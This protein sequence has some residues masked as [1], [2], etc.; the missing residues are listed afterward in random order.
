MEVPLRVVAMRID[1]I[2]W[3]LEDDQEGNF[4]HIVVELPRGNNHEESD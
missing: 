4:W 2:L 1:E 3:D